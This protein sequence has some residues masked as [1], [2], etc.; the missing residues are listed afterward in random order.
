MV[1]TRRQSTLI[2]GLLMLVA[3]ASCGQSPTAP[4]PPQAPPPVGVPVISSM[5]TAVTRTEVEQDVQITADVSPGDGAGTLTYQ[6]TASVGAI[7]GA[8]S[9]VTWRLAEGQAATPADV[10][11]TLTVVKP[12]QALEN[13]QLVSRE[14]RVT[15]QAPNFRVHDSEAEVS[16]MAIRFLT[17]LFADSS[18]SADQALVDF[19]P[20]CPGTADEH[21]DVEQNRRERLITSVEAEVERVTF[22]GDLSAG[23][24]R[25]SCTFSDINRATSA[26]EVWTGTCR[27]D[28]VYRDARWWLCS[29]TFDDRIRL[30]GTPASAEVGQR[31]IPAYWRGDRR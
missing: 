9:S 25:S 14:H 29:S 27:L 19:W 15:R 21:R 18:L 7:T 4:D 11:V 24:V 8:G 1:G 6:W 22:N 10:V 26:P 2:G 20:G 31:P 5:T 3:A 17:E 23:L 13:G 28:V 12:Y 16:R 30:Q